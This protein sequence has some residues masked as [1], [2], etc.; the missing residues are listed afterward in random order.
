MCARVCNVLCYIPLCNSCIKEKLTLTDELIPQAQM[1][2]D[3]Q[4]DRQM[5]RWTHRQRSKGGGGHIARSKFGCECVSAILS[6]CSSKLPFHASMGSCCILVSSHI[7]PLLLSCSIICSVYICTYISSHPV[8]LVVM[9]NT[10]YALLLSG[11]PEKMP[12]QCDPLMCG[13]AKNH[14]AD[15]QNDLDGECN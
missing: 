10:A 15:G 13:S 12:T 4:Q 7:Y 9:H 5:D 14:F 1:A 8:L 3:R 2:T 6:E 11:I